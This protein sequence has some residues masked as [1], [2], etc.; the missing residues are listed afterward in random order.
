MCFATRLVIGRAELAVIFSL[1]LVASL[2]LSKAEASTYCPP[3][4]PGAPTYCGNIPHKASKGS[5]NRRNADPK[6]RFNEAEKDMK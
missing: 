2:G 6:Q 3:K 1:G 4:G 5:S